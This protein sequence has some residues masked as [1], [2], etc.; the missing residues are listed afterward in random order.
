MTSEDWWQ[1][2]ARLLGAYFVVIGA[3][4]ATGAL[5]MF[6]MGVPDGTARWV[7]VLTPLVQGLIFALA[8]A[9][10][11]SRSSRSPAA[12][13]H[14]ASD[15]GATFRRAMQLLGIFFVIAGASEL[16]GTALDTWF[17]DTDWQIRA[18]EVA[19]GLVKASAGAL[20]VWMPAAIAAKLD[21]VRR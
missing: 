21:R 3:V 2:G 13:Q 20:L 15:T 6:G 4:T 10:L 9:W 19:A 14:G 8:G 12:G 1:I 5:M 18:G 17:V 7:V 11:L 16:A